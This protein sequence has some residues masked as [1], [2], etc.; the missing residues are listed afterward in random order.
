V[1]M[2]AFVVLF[3]VRYLFAFM[4]LVVLWCVLGLLLLPYSPC[5]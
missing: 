3:G 5:C 1:V 4:R 2:L